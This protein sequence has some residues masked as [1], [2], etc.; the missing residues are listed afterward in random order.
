MASK[1]GCVGLI[2]R[3][4]FLLESQ[5]LFHNILISCDFD[6]NLHEIKADVQQLNHVFMNII[7]NAAA[8]MEGKGH[9]S[10]RTG[11]VKNKDRIFIEIED[12]GPGIPEDILP[13]IFEP[14]FT[15]KDEGQGTGLGLSMV[16]GIIEN[17]GGTIFAE[18][19]TGKGT[20]FRIELLYGGERGR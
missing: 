8:A 7:L 14:F 16:Y 6:E 20:K 3:T 2:S 1:I 19:L 12:T 17:H 15:T 18:N 9:L 10:I 11:Q 13:H 4:L 5:P